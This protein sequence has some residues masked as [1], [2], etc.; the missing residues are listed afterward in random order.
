MIRRIVS[1]I[2]ILAAIASFVG[3]AAPAFSPAQESNPPKGVLKT[4]DGKFVPAPGYDWVTLLENDHRVRWSPGRQHPTAPN[5]VAA[6]TE[7]KWT[8]ADGFRWLSDTPN[9]L[10]VVQAAKVRPP[11]EEKIKQAMVK[12]L[13][14]SVANAI[15]QAQEDDNIFQ[16]L[17]R[18][19][20]RQGRNEL[21]EGAVSDLFPDLTRRQVAA[22]RRT[23]ALALDGQLTP[24]TWAAK[25]VREEVIA[26]LQKDA[27]ELGR[28]ASIV[29]FISEIAIA[30][31]R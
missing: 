18:G 20:V 7:G 29:D 1:K 27:S 31:N 3:L 26:Q 25:A 5:V 24:T 2:V 8:P 22:I 6:S 11:T 19:V 4:A 17:L 15:G 16:G 13:G 12:I 23:I 14:A 21:I 10:R 28:I 30:S 9:D